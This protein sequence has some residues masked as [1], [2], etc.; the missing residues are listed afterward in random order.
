[1][2]SN[3][4]NRK[5]IA[6]A[7]LEL[8][9]YYARQLTRAALVMMVDDLDDLQ[10]QSILDAIRAYRR[11]PRN[12]TF[13]LPAQL[14]QI[15]SPMVVGQA[16]GREILGR[17]TAAISKFG[18]MGSSQARE[19]IGELGWKVISEHGGWPAFCQSDVLHNAAMQAQIRERLADLAQYGSHELAS[20]TF[21]KQTPG[22]SRTSSLGPA[23]SSVLEIV[24]STAKL[25]P[26]D[27]GSE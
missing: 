1:M 18:Y 9:D 7:L 14:R 6:N 15:L 10:P 26:L 27:N 2:K 12:R 16:P 21:L 22:E 25:R 24:K 5:I 4:E 23:K 19:E 3:A 20:M 8:S 13:P 11:D 17:M